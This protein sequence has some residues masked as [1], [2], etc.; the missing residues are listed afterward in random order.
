M[1]AIITYPDTELR[2]ADTSKIVLDKI[3]QALN[4][5]AGCGGSGGGGGGAVA[6]CGCVI[7]GS[8]V[9]TAVPSLPLIPYIYTDLDTGS[10]FTWNVVSQSW[11]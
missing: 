2:H 3:L 5:G 10:T 7:Q 8:G 1:S 4:N 9:P 11:M 6:T